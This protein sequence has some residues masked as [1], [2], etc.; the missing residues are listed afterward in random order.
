MTPSLASGNV[1]VEKFMEK[2]PIISSNL[3]KYLDSLYPNRCADLSLSDREVWFQAGQR[4]VIDF[5]LK[6]K[7]EQE[8]GDIDPNTT[9]DVPLCS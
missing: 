2:I 9:I 5:L 3:L 6:A 7:E 4:S 1:V 8:N